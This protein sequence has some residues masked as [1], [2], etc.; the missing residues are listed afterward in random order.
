MRFV[1]ALFLATAVGCSP[2]AGEP[3][4]PPPQSAPVSPPVPPALPLP[5]FVDVSHEAGL[6]VE[7]HTG[8]ATEKDWL[9]SAMGGGAIVLDYDLDGDVDVIVVDGTGLTPAGELVLDDAW[10]TR[11]FR[12]DGGWRFTDVTDEAGI[13]V[14][15]FGFGGA[16]CDYDAD[17]DPDV[18]LC[19]WGRNHLLRNRGDGTFEDVTESAGLLGDVRDM[20]TGCAWG[21]VNGDG[22][23]D[24]YVANYCDQHEFIEMQR[25]SGRPG[26]TCE[27]RDLFVWCGP[28]GLPAQADRLYLGTKEGRFRELGEQRL[29]EQEPRYAFQPILTDVDSDGDLDIYVVNDTT[30]NTLWIN[31][32]RGRFTDMGTVAG[33]ATAAD[34]RAQA[35]MGVDAADIDRDGRIDLFVT[36]YSHDHDTLYVNGTRTPDTPR[37]RDRTARH[38]LVQPGFLRLGW[39]TRLFDFDND[40]ELDVFVA[41]GHVF[42]ELDGFAGRTGTTYAQR[43]LLLRGQGAPDH[44]FED[45]TDDAGPGLQ[46][47]RVWRGA[48]FAD[49][50]DDG[51]LDVLVTALNGRAAL[52][53]NEGGERNAFLRFRLVGEGG[54]RDPSGVRVTVVTADGRRL[55]E[56][57]HHGA[58]FLGDN[59]PRLSFG[60]GSDEVVPRV[61]V[62]WP[63]GTEQAFEEVPTRTRYVVR[64]GAAEL[65]KE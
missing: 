49:F 50:D 5:Q 59:D 29:R 48:A 6:V 15:C 25:E 28:R 27:W 60:L 32:G 55:M 33:V 18:F 7:N 38:G 10:R 44:R 22:I 24:L 36:N 53:R 35:G 51:D 21:D 47:E 19:A 8:S 3:A 56:E 16:A 2:P 11:L 12:N 61:E 23:H 4:G 65:S 45:I 42:G 63:D 62:R 40:G 52:L 34:A 41:C 39:G 17:G 1:A 26:R 30:A 31:D 43:C 46:L 37:F 13:D 54:Q 64:Q 14:R 58:S 9:V 20:S 57:L